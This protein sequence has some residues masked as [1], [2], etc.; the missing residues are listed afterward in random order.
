MTDARLTDEPDAAP[1]PEKSVDGAE[2]RNTDLLNVY[3]HPH[4]PV[5]FVDESYRLPGQ[6]HGPGYHYVAAVIVDREVIATVGTA[7]TTIAGGGLTWHTTDE[8]L[9]AAGQAR[10]VTFTD[11][12][13]ANSG[14]SQRLVRERISPL[15]WCGSA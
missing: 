4:G 9:D 8:A 12:V 15:R 11:F 1:P 3:A 5:A 6:A 2:F 10:I 7:L 14:N 13:A